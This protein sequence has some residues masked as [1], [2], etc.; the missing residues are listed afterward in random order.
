MEGPKFN[1]HEPQYEKVEDLPRGQ[2]HKFSD[3]KEGGFVRKSADEHLIEAEKKSVRMED[4]GMISEMPID[5]LHQEALDWEKARKEMMEY[6]STLEKDSRKWDENWEH[7]FTPFIA[8]DRELLLQAIKANREEILELAGFRTL[9]NESSNR[10]FENRSH[11]LTVRDRRS[12]SGGGD[13]IEEA[14]FLND[15]KDFMLKAIAISPRTYKYASKRLKVDREVALA[16]FRG[17]GGLINDWDL[18]RSGFLAD[19]EMVLTAVSSNESVIEHVYDALK[20]SGDFILEALKVN[21]RC[22]QY[23]ID[24]FK[25]NEEMVRVAITQDARSYFSA[26]ERVRGMKDVA[27]FAINS[28]AMGDRAP[29]FFSRMLRTFNWTDK[30]IVLAIVD[31]IAKE[32]GDV[33]YKWINDLSCGMVIAKER[34]ELVQLLA[35][36]MQDAI[37][38]A[39]NPQPVVE[40]AEAVELE[41]ASEP[42]KPKKKKWFSI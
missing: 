27:L 36:E 5:Y 31:R 18:N 34:P 24:A 10:I 9:S 26:S 2:Q 22:L 3:I 33:G 11:G 21:G 32:D 41:P 4:A 39:S 17:N 28:I 20:H 6:F 19:K 1:P 40:V 15:D 38:K 29:Y 8:K 7:E 35:K 14:P 42:E 30:D 12:R 13:N 25:D 16:A 23:V 37:D